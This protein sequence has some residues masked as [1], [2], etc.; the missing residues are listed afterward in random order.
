M[1]QQAG[2]NHPTNIPTGAFKTA[3]G[4]INIGASGKTIWERLCR[5]LGAEELLDDPAFATNALRSENRDA[6]TIE[7]ERRLACASGA[8]W[9]DRLNQAGV[10]CG[11]I[12]SVDQVFADPQVQHLGMVETV[13]SP[14]YNPLRLVAQGVS[15]SR[16]PSEVRLRPPEC[17]EHTDEILS[18]LGYAPGEIADLRSRRVV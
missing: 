6:L 4:Y 12:Y 2:N 3:D 14:Y 18:S 1:P 7:I 5:S 15:L 9:I 10:P 17:G 8:T 11:R 13:A 16:T